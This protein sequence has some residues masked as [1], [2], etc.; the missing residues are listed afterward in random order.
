VID[1]L[2]EKLA[3]LCDDEH[4]MC[5]VATRKGIFCRGFAQWK[6]H[7]LKSRHDW[8]ARSRPGLAR[9]ELEDLIN[10]WQL[11]RQ[12]LNGFPL[13]CDTQ[14]IEHRTCDGWQGFTDEEL[15]GFCVELGGEAVEIVPAEEVPA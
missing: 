5:E 15:A 13:A 12:Y 6:T 2:R 14:A 11:A 10:R 3:K 9:K 8:I 7:E 1:E 4:S